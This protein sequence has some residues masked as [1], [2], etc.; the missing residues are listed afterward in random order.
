MAEAV[1]ILR[2]LDP[3]EF[4]DLTAADFQAMQWFSEKRQWTIYDW[5]SEEGEGGSFE[6]KLKKENVQRMLF[7]LSQQVG[8]R[9]FVPTPAEQAAFTADLQAGLF[10]ITDTLAARSKPSFGMFVKRP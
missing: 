7:G 6:S 10:L 5:T 8:V 3:A 1:N 2:E 9:K 4:G